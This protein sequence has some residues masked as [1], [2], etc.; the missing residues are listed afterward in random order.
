MKFEVD[1]DFHGSKRFE[2]E[3]PNAETARQRIV[4]L[5]ADGDL[6]PADLEKS[7]W[8]V[9]DARPVKVEVKQF[10]MLPRKEDK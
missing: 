1:A 9:S 10:K 8:I 7:E 4:D 6:E 5:I 3:A 2:V